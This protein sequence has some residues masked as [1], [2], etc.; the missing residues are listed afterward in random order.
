[1]TLGLY[2]H[3]VPRA[4]AWRPAGSGESEHWG[5]RSRGAGGRRHFARCP[6]WS[7]AGPG[8]GKEGGG[9]SARVQVALRGAGGEASGSPISLCAGGDIGGTPGAGSSCGCRSCVALRTPA[10]PSAGDALSLG[11][12]R[13]G[14]TAG[15]AEAAQGDSGRVPHSGPVYGI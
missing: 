10:V 5:G 7:V 4:P 15:R 6:L 3:S 9:R 11:R 14:T 12:N 13:S 8:G 2:P 1:M